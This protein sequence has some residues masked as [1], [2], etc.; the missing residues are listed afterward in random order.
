MNAAALA[1]LTAW[2]VEAGLAGK[3][4]S[5][6]LGGFCRRAADGGLPIARAGVIIDTLHPIHEG[7]VFRWRNDDTGDPE[8]LEYGP[9][10]EGVAATSWQASPFFRMLQD[11]SSWLRRRLARSETPEFPG[12]VDHQNDGM[13]DY[14]ALINRFAE[15]GAIGEMDCVYSYWVTDRPDGFEDRHIDALVALMP[16]LALAVKCVSLA[17]IAETLVETYLGRDAGRRVLGGLIRRGV[18]ETISAALWFSDLRDFTRI[19]DQAEPQ[20]LIPFLN[21]YAETAIS[22]IH[23]Q[24]GDVLKLIG[25]GVLA[26]F[27]APTSEAACASALA[28]EA[29]LRR[30]LA[31]LNARRG[32]GGLPTTEIYLG[33]HLGEVFYGNI[34]SRERLDFT[35]VGP[36][37]NEVS[38]IAA[39]CRSLDRRLLVSE[40][41]AAASAEPDRAVLVSVGRYALRGVARPQH[42]FTRDPTAER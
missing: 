37:V 34:G 11:G 36:A 26:V 27:A 42:L 33:L 41:F 32:D 3:S 7:R 19:A 29:A 30:E 24:G 28:A 20:Q 31:A 21:D 38:R 6:I 25:D 18:A 39:M 1:E 17:R 9:T 15:E 13:T 5:A 12:L 8:F 4:E 40:A 22:A 10:N 14:L 35:V 2:V 16:K 23:A